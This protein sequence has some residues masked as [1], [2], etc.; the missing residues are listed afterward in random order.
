MQPIEGFDVAP[1]AIILCLLSL[2]ASFL[3]NAVPQHH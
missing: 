3:C 1:S 2:E